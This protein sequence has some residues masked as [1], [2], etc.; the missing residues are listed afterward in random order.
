VIPK[1]ELFVDTGIHTGYALFNGT[2]NPL[3]GIINHEAALRKTKE[4]Y[5]RFAGETFANLLDSLTPAH[6][7]LEEP[8]LWSGSLKSQVAGE[9]GALFHLQTCVITYA[10][11]CAIKNIPFTLVSPGAWKGQLT[12][13]ATDYRIKLISGKVYDNEHIADSVAMGLRRDNDL[14]MLRRPLEKYEK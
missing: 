4:N 6:V 2:V 7:T 11:R 8:E 3:T 10:D 1:N 5:I 14:W 13:E 9:T 12:K